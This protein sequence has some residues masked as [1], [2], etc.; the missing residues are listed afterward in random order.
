MSVL[1]TG[2]S[3]FVGQN[4]VAFLKSK[5]IPTV[6]ISLREKRALFIPEHSSTLI[7]LAGKAHDL[8]KTSNEAEYFEINTELTKLVYRAF[9]E[10]K[11]D[12]FIYMSSVKAVADNPSEVVDEETLAKPITAY[13]KSKLAAEEYLLQ[14]KKEGTRLYVLRPCM[15]HGPKNKGNL[16]ILYRLVRKGIPYPLGR[17]SNNRS[18]L[19]IENLNFVV[20]ELIRNKRIE[21][22]VYSLADSESLSTKDLV[23]LIG[24]SLGKKPMVLSPPI[25]LV[26][27]LAQIGDV[28]KLALN[29]ERLQ[30]LTGSYLVSNKKI[31]KAIGRKLPMSAKEGFLLTFRSFLT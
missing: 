5:K 10:S 6:S 23:Y 24:E 12:T 2:A 18:Y 19:S 30:K 16:N 4:L 11:G 20:Y 17:F 13:G 15:I 21:S 3:G 29:T 31:E 14:N 22:G 7:H 26:K 28:F 1:I 9:C 25:E 27:V 8:K